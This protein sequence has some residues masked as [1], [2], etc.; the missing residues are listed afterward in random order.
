MGFEPA[1]QRQYVLQRLREWHQ[2]GFPSAMQY[3][4]RPNEAMPT[5][6]HILENLLIKFLNCSLDFANCFLS[7]GAGAPPRL[8]HLNQPHMAFLRNTMDQKFHPQPAP[9][10]EV[11]IAT[12]VWRLRPGITNIPEALGLLLLSLR[13]HSCSYGSFPQALREAVEAA[14]APPNPLASAL[15]W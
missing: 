13:R 5:D 7:G 8:M 11:V 3:D 2:R 4:W 1:A 14:E 15:S 10:Y 9:H 12:K 6:A